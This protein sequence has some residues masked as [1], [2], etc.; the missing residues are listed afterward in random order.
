[1]LKQFTSVASMLL[2]T[3]LLSACGG[4]GNRVVSALDRIQQ[5]FPAPPALFAKQID[6][7]GRPAIATALISPL[8]DPGPRGVDRDASGAAQQ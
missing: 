3:L 1:M 7:E 8:K 2:A 5:A 6:R 4:D